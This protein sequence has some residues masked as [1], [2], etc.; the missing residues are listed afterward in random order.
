MM[1]DVSRPARLPSEAVILPAM[2]A[3]KREYNRGGAVLSSLRRDWP[4]I[5]QESLHTLNHALEDDR[6]IMEPAQ[7]QGYSNVA[8]FTMG[9]AAL[10]S[11]LRTQAR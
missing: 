10:Q 4:E 5:P 2:D 11:V 9:R 7:G 3:A 8:G 1:D 6:G